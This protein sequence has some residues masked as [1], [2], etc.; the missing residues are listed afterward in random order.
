MKS[1]LPS[2]VTE[3]RLT[4]SLSYWLSS[5][6][7]SNVSAKEA[8]T[9]AWIILRVESAPKSAGLGRNGARSRCKYRDGKVASLLSVASPASLQLFLADANA[10]GR[11]LGVE[12]GTLV[13]RILQLDPVYLEP[14]HGC[15]RES[16]VRMRPEVSCGSGR[17]RSKCEW[18]PRSC[19]QRK[20]YEVLFVQQFHFSFVS[21]NASRHPD[22]QTEYLNHGNIERRLINVLVIAR[23]STKPPKILK[24]P[25]L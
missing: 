5:I 19:L 6:S 3:T 18:T 14:H 23:F 15:Y 13:E 8:F 22:L 20:G 2:I 10:N 11:A 25:L 24:T 9:P 21:Q 1:S 4:S 12:F 7:N 17:R 16:R